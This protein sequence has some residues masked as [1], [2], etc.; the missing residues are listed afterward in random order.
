VTDPQHQHH[1]STAAHDG[2]DPR[3]LLSRQHLL[4]PLTL[5]YLAA[6]AIATLTFWSNTPPTSATTVSV[7]ALFLLAAAAIGTRFELHISDTTSVTSNTIPVLVGIIIYP[8]AAP[9]FGVVLAIA[10]FP[11]WIGRAM[12]TATFVMGCVAAGTAVLVAHERVESPSIIWISLLCSL[13]VTGINSA[14]IAVFMAGVG[15]PSLR[16]N[17]RLL[18]GTTAAS[19]LLLFPVT[20]LIVAAH[21]EYGF[22]MLPMVVIPLFLVQYFHG[23]YHKKA[24]LT[25][26]L[27]ATNEKLARSNLQ[28]AAAMVRALDARDA[29]TAGHSA[30]VAVYS[31]DIAR[32]AGFD[33]HTVR[34]AHLAGLLHDIGKIGVR[35]SILNKT[36]P[37]D[38]EEYEAM[39]EH[40][41]I[42]AEILAEVDAY[43]EIST[44]VR[45]HHERMDGR[46]YPEGIGG[47]AIPAISR[48]ISVADTYSALTTDRPYRDGMPTE[49]AM[50][51]LG[52]ASGSGQLDEMFTA[53][54]LRILR[55]A[56]DE[57]QRG[58]HSS[59][60]VEIARHEAL[61]H[62]TPE[63]T[64]DFEPRPAM[65]PGIQAA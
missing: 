56:D 60:D 8:E 37:L 62:F 15:G 32:E 12:S 29:Y 42:G 20:A 61:V 33:D 39:K 43:A 30:A 58:K 9:L 46:G 14:S 3:A 25:K 54:F 49:K 23:L 36:A 41:R 52:E 27:A 1:A 51:I 2:D 7:G 10:S 50:K 48:M 31:R 18:T 64:S 53:V 4:V 22:W 65:Q 40:A 44:Y 16:S 55:S 19:T 11:S 47:E 13:L 17:L 34:M 59:F 26:D 28:F 45:Y 24:L 21:R 6:A 38:D 57:Y 63:A 35:G 5:M